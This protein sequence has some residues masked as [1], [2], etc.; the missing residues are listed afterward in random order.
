MVIPA[1]TFSNHFFL[2]L[3]IGDALGIKKEKI[4]IAQLLLVYDGF[5]HLNTHISVTLMTKTSIV[6]VDVMINDKCK[7]HSVC[8][9]GPATRSNAVILLQAIPT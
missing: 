9:S 2:A 8:A 5:C 1:F 6:F 3:G 4:I 7:S